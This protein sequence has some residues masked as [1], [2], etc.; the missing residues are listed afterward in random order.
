M[1]PENN[2]AERA[3]RP[4]V[5]MR[6]VTGGSRSPTGADIHAVNTSGIATELKKHS[7]T[8]ASIFEVILPLITQAG[9]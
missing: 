1:L 2:T 4:Q 5:V 3:I 6:K 9:E 8:N 7:Q